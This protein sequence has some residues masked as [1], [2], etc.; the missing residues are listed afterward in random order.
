[1]AEK[2]LNILCRE[3]DGVGNKIY[4]TARAMLTLIFFSCLNSNS[5]NLLSLVII[6]DPYNGHKKGTKK[7]L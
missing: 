5:M 2:L 7:D 6:G 4:F 1:L 3:W